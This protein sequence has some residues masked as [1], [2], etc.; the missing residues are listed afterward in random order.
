MDN[1]ETKS[2]EIESSYS[3]QTLSPIYT[4]HS[5]PTTFTPVGSK[6]KSH[7]HRF[8]S[9]AKRSRSQRTQTPTPRNA[10]RNDDMIGVGSGLAFSHLNRHLHQQT[11]GTRNQTIQQRFRSQY[12]S[13]DNK[14]QSFLLNLIA[15]TSSLPS[16][17]FSSLS[18]PVMFGYTTID[19]GISTPL[20]PQ[21]EQ[22]VDAT[23]EDIQ[24]GQ[25]IP[26]RQY[27]LCVAASTNVRLFVEFDLFSDLSRTRTNTPSFHKFF[28]RLLEKT[29]DTVKS[30]F[31]G[32]ND[33]TYSTYVM[34][35][36]I[37]SRPNWQ[38][39]IAHRA[40]IFFDVM[41]ELSTAAIITHA[42][43]NA[44]GEE[45]TKTCDSYNS[46]PYRIEGRNPYLSYPDHGKRKN[47]KKTRVSLPDRI[48]VTPP[49]AC[50]LIDCVCKVNEKDVQP[51]RLQEAKK[52][53]PIHCGFC[54]NNLQRRQVL[55][56]TPYGLLVRDDA[57]G[58]YIVKSWKKMKSGSERKQFILQSSLHNHSYALYQPSFRNAKRWSIGAMS[59]DVI[60]MKP[61]SDT[62]IAGP[63]LH[64]CIFP[65]SC[66]ETG[67]TAYKMMNLQLLGITT[68][69]K[70]NSFE[71]GISRPSSTMI[72]KLQQE[73]L[74][75]LFQSNCNNG[76]YD[77]SQMDIRDILVYDD[78]SSVSLVCSYHT[79][80]CMI[81]QHDCP[82]FIIIK[83]DSAYVI[84]CRS[85][86]PIDQRSRKLDVGGSWTN[87]A[88]RKLKVMKEYI[89][90]RA[91]HLLST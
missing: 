45:L 13:I 82:G 6:R 86:T 80:A 11:T 53:H 39:D 51:I 14:G 84:C 27:Q 62:Q 25:L 78:M 8:L 50:N 3:Q 71:R 57:K 61:S 24:K 81:C 20:D 87:L 90:R 88:S 65:H 36:D 73:I 74:V 2:Y 67:Y 29:Y 4:T 23:C 40:K 17:S 43:F 31:P 26:V 66:R 12:V 59:D 63:N 77:E 54:G 7:G 42:V 55:Q 44:I 33:V 30:Y 19:N 35:M 91:D 75:P 28:M 72:N 49:Y 34:T 79:S 10:D 58:R 52:I 56:K 9:H 1:Y 64:Y 89:V 16:S 21:Q 68:F 60:C 70:R 22:V 41:V 76:D 38:F 47:S 83:P 32:Q 48:Y 18:S 69:C 85:R 46:V 5:Q 37:V 15:M